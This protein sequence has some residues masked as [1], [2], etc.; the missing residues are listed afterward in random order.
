M[1]RQLQRMATHDPLTGLPNRRLFL[2][3]LSQVLA[4]RRG[5]GLACLYLD[6][7]GFK[8]VNDR[9]GHAV[10]DRLL[11]RV[12]E[13]ISGCVRLSDLTARLGG[14]EFAVILIGL[15]S[16]DNARMMTQRI[17]RAITATAEVD[18]QAV[19]VSASIGI[20]FLP[21]STSP[22]MV[23]ADALIKSADEAMYRAKKSGRGQ[24]RLVEWTDGPLGARAPLAESADVESERRKRI[25]IG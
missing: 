19:D 4:A 2:N 11:V 24:L 12:A 14:D 15:T 8:V 10:G 25:A 3:S 18:G 6:L 16:P 21:A 7:D 9:S 17:I 22:S 20:A 23:S 13:T 1:Q 5:G